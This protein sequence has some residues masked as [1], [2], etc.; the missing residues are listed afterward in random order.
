MTFKIN[1]FLPTDYIST[2]PNN[3]SYS[4][5]DLSR[6]NEEFQYTDVAMGNTTNYDPLTTPTEKSYRFDTGS[7]KAWSAV[8]TANITS[9]MAE[10]SKVIPAMFSLRKTWKFVTCFLLCLTLHSPAFSTSPSL[11]YLYLRAGENIA[12]I[13]RCEI[14]NKETL[15][16]SINC[17][18]Y[19]ISGTKESPEMQE[20]MTREFYRGMSHVPQTI[21]TKQCKDAQFK[22]A[23]Y[24]KICKF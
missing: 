7:L 8:D 4:L 15:Q 12:V 11:S 10:W 20:E 18:A 9:A 14:E 17:I 24:T 1:D 5:T 19:F 13:K 21:T 16:K 22:I 3:I 23:G 6:V 2:L